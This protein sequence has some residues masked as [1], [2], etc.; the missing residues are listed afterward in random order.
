MERPC[1][2]AIMEEHGMVGAPVPL[3]QVFWRR[4]NLRRRRPTARLGELAAEVLAR[5]PSRRSRKL[6]ELIEA[7]R[8]AVPAGYGRR[9]RI[10]A[11]ARGRLIVIVDS[12]A[13]KYFFGRQLGERL[14]TSLNE[15]LGAAVVNRI[16]YRIG[17]PVT[18]S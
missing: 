15:Q 2:Q 1:R 10:E 11:F 14:R 7:W 4:Y 5:G 8:A 13:T 3:R 9:S 12:A 18:Q 6:G 16:D 17:S